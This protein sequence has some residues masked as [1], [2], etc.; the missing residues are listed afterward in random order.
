MS[1][2]DELQNKK[3]SVFTDLEMCVL[4]CGDKQKYDINYINA[5]LAATELAD[6]NAELAALRER[7]EEAELRN[8]RALEWLEHYPSQ[9]DQEEQAE[10]NRRRAILI[11]SGKMKVKP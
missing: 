5:L 2:L 1:A 8:K 11:L 10:V 6:K 4:Y 3:E 9:D 7:L